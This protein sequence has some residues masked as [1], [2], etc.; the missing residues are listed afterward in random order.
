VKHGD[1]NL[2]RANDLSVQ[3]PLAGL[4]PKLR[5][6]CPPDSKKLE[7]RIMSA[8][9][10]FFRLSKVR[11]VGQNRCLV[12]ADKGPSLAI[13]ELDDG[14]V[15]IHRFAGCGVDEMLSAVGLEMRCLFPERAQ[16][17]RVAGK[18]QPFPAADVLRYVTFEAFV[19]VAAGV[20][21]CS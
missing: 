16:N 14:R 7:Y 12:P 4:S 5:N 1:T 3:R 20:R 15:F 6:G 19:I 8:E 11:R 21:S 13:R 9:K 10:R 17:D 18:R 2:Q